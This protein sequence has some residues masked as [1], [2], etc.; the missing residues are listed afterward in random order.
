M[1][2]LLLLVLLCFL[3]CDYFEKPT[4]EEQTETTTKTDTENA[5][6]ISVTQMWEDY[7]VANPNEATSERPE[8]WFFHNNKADADRLGKLVAAGKKQAGSGLYIWYEEASA[9]LPES[10]T[11]HIITDFDGKALAIIETRKVDTI[12][13]NKITAE[14]ASL[15]MGT[16]EQPLEKWKKAHSDFFTMALAESNDTFLEDMLVVCEYFETIWPRIAPEI[17]QNSVSLTLKKARFTT[18]S[19]PKELTV[20]MYNTTAAP[21]MTGLH[22]SIDCLKDSAWKPM[23]PDM[24]FNDIGYGI[25]QNGSQPFVI[26][27]L[28]EQISYK[29]GTYRISKS[30]LDENY[31]KTHKQYPVYAQ[32]EIE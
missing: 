7:T 5:V 13:F 2:Q 12:P 21:I 3:S 26:D 27:L 11:K 15:D 18:T 25:D 32:F 9:P 30:Y 16:D 23:V 29:T 22:Y 14:Y 24:V 4:T 20:V 1:K 8:S 28:R 6:D 31:S 10:G 17:P 19:L